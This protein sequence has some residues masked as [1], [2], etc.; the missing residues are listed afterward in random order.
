MSSLNSENLK[1]PSLTVF[2]LESSNKQDQDKATSLRIKR[3]NRPTFPVRFN[4]RHKV[5]SLSQLNG[6][7][8]PTLR[9]PIC[10]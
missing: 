2:S 6:D 7:H 10:R 1:L 3:Y 4:K 5:K 8:L 9:K